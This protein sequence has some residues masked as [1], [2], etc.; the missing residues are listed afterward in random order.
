VKVALDTA[1]AA[2]VRRRHAE[3]ECQPTA[4]GDASAIVVP[5]DEFN[6]PIPV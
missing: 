2:M 6:I 5:L 3:L 1:V 4:S